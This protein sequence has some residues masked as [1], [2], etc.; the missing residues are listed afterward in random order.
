MTAA[1][2]WSSEISG[3]LGLSGKVRIGY[4]LRDLP[5]AGNRNVKAILLALN[6]IPI[7]TFIPVIINSKVRATLLALK[8]DVPRVS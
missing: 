1:L 3:R 8:D 4:P 2:Y 6:L 7:M 5:P